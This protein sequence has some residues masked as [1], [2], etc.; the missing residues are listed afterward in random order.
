[1]IYA[2]QARSICRLT[3]EVEN[4]FGD[5]WR[6]HVEYFLWDFGLEASP[7][8]GTVYCDDQSLKPRARKSSRNILEAPPV[9]NCRHFREMYLGSPA[10]HVRL[11]LINVFVLEENTSL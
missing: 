7:G 11:W 5:S 10:K 8:A 9:R 4:D 3:V 6:G 2:R 1:M